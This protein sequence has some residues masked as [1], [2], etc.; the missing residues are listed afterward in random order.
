MAYKWGLLITYKSC[1]H[2]TIHASQQ[3]CNNYNLQ[4]QGLLKKTLIF[5]TNQTPPGYRTKH[6]KT[7]MKDPKTPHSLL[8]AELF[9]KRCGLVDEDD[10]GRNE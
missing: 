3:T 7:L 8:Q 1:W 5:F 2:E 6:Q 4:L 9:F 10:E